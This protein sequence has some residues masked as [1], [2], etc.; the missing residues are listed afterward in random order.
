MSC[1]V[2]CG[3]SAPVCPSMGAL[4]VNFVEELGNKDYSVSLWFS[5]EDSV[6]VN[7]NF[8]GGCVL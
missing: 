2:G 8:K 4:T 3:A 5:K 1:P 6:I 7:V